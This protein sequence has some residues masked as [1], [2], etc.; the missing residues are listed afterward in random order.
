MVSP[1]P[2]PTLVLL[3]PWLVVQTQQMDTLPGL[4]AKQQDE[5]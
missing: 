2:S 5:M 4:A 1:C 3:Q